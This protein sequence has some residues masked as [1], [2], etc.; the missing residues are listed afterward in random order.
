MIR[1]IIGLF[2]LVSTLV[3]ED[4]ESCYTVQLVS[5]FAS[6]DSMSRLKNEEFPSSCKLMKISQ[7][8]TVR[9]GCYEKIAKAKKSLHKLK[10]NYKYAYIATTYKYRFTDK[11]TLRTQMNKEPKIEKVMSADSTD[12]FI[13]KDEELKLMLQSF[14]Y[15][16][17]LKNAYRTAKIGYR[18]N[19]NSYYWNQK[20]AEISRW[21][22]RGTEAVKYMKFMYYKKYDKKL[23]KEIIDYG[24]KAYQYEDIE[25]LVVDKALRNPTNKNIDAMIFIHSEIG[26][27]ENSAEILLKEYD[28]NPSK[29]IYLI[30]SLQIYLNM[31]DMESAK[32]V[33]QKMEKRRPYSA[34]EAE[35]IA[36]YYYLKKD[37]NSAYEALLISSKNGAGKK[38]YELLSDLAWYLQ[39][40]ES[41]ANASVKL[42]HMNRAR[43]VDYERIA[44]M[45][46]EKN[47]S[48]VSE[49]S[50]RAYKEHK[51]SYI[52][53]TY[54]NYSLKFKKYDELNSKITQLDLENSTI[55]DE[56]YYWLIK[57]QLYGHYHQND[58]AIQAL[59]KALELDPNSMQVQLS[60]LYFYIA[61]GFDSELKIGLDALSEQPNL[62]KDFYFP[63]ASSYFYLQDINRAAY[64]V[65]KIKEENVSIQNSL[66]FKFL[67]A[68]IFQI[69]N[70]QNAFMMKLKEIKS[71][72]LK[73]AQLNSSLL[74]NDEYLNNL[75]NADINLIHADEFEKELAEAKEYLSEE[76][77]ERLNYSWAI[78]KH[79]QE[80]SNEIYQHIKVKELWM[81]FS[82]ALI[83]QKHSEI[84]DLLDAYLKL[85]PIGDAS[86]ASYNDGQ[87]ALAQTLAFSTLNKNDDSQNAYIQH[88]GL[89][90]ERTDL[91][92]VKP[93][94]YSRNPLKQEYIALE[95]RTYLSR[96]W[97]LYSKLNYYQN[98]TINDAILLTVPE[99]SIEAGFA[100]RKVF[101]RGF[102]EGD[103]EYHNSMESYIS[104]M[105]RGEYRFNHY[106]LGGLALA[107]NINAN[108]STQLLLGG[109]KDMIELKFLFNFLPSTS[110]ETLYQHNVYNSQ[111][112]VNLGSGEY[113][114]VILSHQ[115]R[116]GYPDLR[117]GTFIDAGTYDETEGTRGIIDTL[118]GPNLVALPD[119]FYNIGLNFLYGMV[120]SHIYTRV[121]RPY[122][123]VS[124]YY[125]SFS[126]DINYGL[127]AGYGGKVN[128]QDHLVFG[129]SYTQSVNGVGGSIFELFLKYEFLYVSP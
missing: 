55:R 123:E 36:Y 128:N 6:E 62:N 113:A 4:K 67:D 5:A 71:D 32:V 105:L 20:M 66:D 125:N 43:V 64:F 98:K 99:D 82:N 2:F 106:F 12:G 37:M 11:N 40:Y 30:K 117:V 77:Y 44:Q 85:L 8:L 27:P 45:K 9:C 86:S 69:R 22:G 26:N 63:I 24:I 96:N 10:P 31:G 103:V 35:L 111:D 42:Y 89:V 109:K 25:P 100:L 120:N 52:F 93:S 79:E 48:L 115:I 53:Y 107:N 65:D 38:Y 15:V 119:D 84:E 23:Q 61:N 88:L 122:F 47:L 50:F 58:L 46:K 28:K 70:N 129:T 80:L 91:F 68:Y 33:V 16:N 101:R 72:L 121:W 114:R 81:R 116:N 78:R 110:I 76:N 49:S 83:Q 3:A 57:A 95:N 90:K 17:D 7:N 112:D 13:T 18:R 34:K 127:N 29:N 54:A 56:S 97:Y 60:I 74:H 51:V 14:L 75:L 87:T 126:E 108:E 94:Y 104:Y 1:V 19:P 92:S 118:Q 73:Q 39:K 124:S 59:K 102:L 41:G 21:S